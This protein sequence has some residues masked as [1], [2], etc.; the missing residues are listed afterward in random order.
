[1]LEMREEYTLA[2]TRVGF[3]FVLCLK[4]NSLFFG[5]GG[6]GLNDVDYLKSIVSIRRLVL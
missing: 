5:D 1:M 3:F 4:L 2:T 6:R